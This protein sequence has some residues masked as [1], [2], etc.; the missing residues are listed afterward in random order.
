MERKALFLVGPTG[1]GKSE[2]ALALAQALK[3]EII[4]CDAMQVYKGMDIGTAKPPSAEQRKIPHH[5]IDLI[6]PRSEHSVFKHRELAL[7]AM[8]RIF[9]RN[10]L[11]IVV[12]GSGLYV[13]AIINGLA[14]LPGKRTLLRKKLEA[15]ARKKG[16]LSLY[17]EL[18][19]LAPKRASKIHPND[20]KRIIRA[21]EIALVSKDDFIDWEFPSPSPLP[22]GERVKG[23]GAER[24]YRIV[25]KKSQG[26]WEC[27]RQGLESI[28]IR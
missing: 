27:H 17:A 21:L 12:G 14:P 13:K 7:K 2:V 3:G 10:R 22:R 18:R 16:P 1:S 5:L 26:D 8:V 9:S 11:P 20:Q 6:S 23:E 24:T 15:R 19:K 4:S 25:S 28:G